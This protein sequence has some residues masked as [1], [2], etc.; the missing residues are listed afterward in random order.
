MRVRGGTALA[1]TGVLTVTGLV[2][3]HSGT[4][5]DVVNLLSGLPRDGIVATDEHG[6]QRSGPWLVTSGTLLTRDGKLWSGVP[7][8][9]PPAPTRGRTGSAV[10]RAVS[11]RRD[12]QDVHVY[13]R[14]RSATLST[15]ARTPAHAWD[16]VHVFL[17]YRDQ[18]HLYSVDLQR[19]DGTLTIKRKSVGYE[20][21]AQGHP[22]AAATGS[23]RTYDISVTDTPVGP[24]IS[25]A[26][27]GRLVLQAVDHD[28]AALQE[29]GRVGLRGDNAD[30]TVGAFRVVPG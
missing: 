9:G 1:V 5:D 12:F 28:R 24:R 10:L 23:W 21:L 13:L 17:R 27:D 2:L 11:V 25:L 4:D 22:P 20:T 19:R 15:T 26:M 18:D 16:G 8:A 7:D 30:F 6:P 3:S 29:P 14:L